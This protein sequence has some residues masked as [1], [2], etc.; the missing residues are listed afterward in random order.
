MHNKP[1]MGPLDS[2]TRSGK[3]IDTIIDS[4]WDCD[5]IKTNLCDVDY[6]VKDHKEVLAHNLQWS[7][8]HQPTDND[9]CVLLGAWVQENFLLNAC[10]IIKLAHP[11][12]WC[13]WPDKNEYVK[14]ALLKIKP[15]N[16]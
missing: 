6:F 16:P 8:V 5:C 13:Q 11:A 4:L 12:A 14:N 15:L 3:I 9:M 7:K 1:G 2:K 10:K